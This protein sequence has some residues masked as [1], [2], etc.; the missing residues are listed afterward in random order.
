MSVANFLSESGFRGFGGD[1][2]FGFISN[3]KPWLAAI[4]LAQFLTLSSA[5]AELSTGQ[6][7][8]GVGPDPEA[9]APPTR[10]EDGVCKVKGREGAI[11]KVASELADKAITTGKPLDLTPTGIMP[12]LIEHD[13]TV[14][15]YKHLLEVYNEI[16]ANRTRKE[17]QDGE[18][19]A[20]GKL[21][22]DLDGNVKPSWKAF[23]SPFWSNLAET[24]PL[25]FERLKHQGA[26]S[27]AWE[28][29]LA[30]IKARFADVK[31]YSL[32]MPGIYTGK[33]INDETVRAYQFNGTPYP[34]DPGQVRRALAD[35]KEGI[36]REM[37][38][39]NLSNVELEALASEYLAK[40]LPWT[41][42]LLANTPSL[43]SVDHFGVA[44]LDNYYKE[45]ATRAKNLPERVNEMTERDPQVA[46]FRKET[47]HTNG[48]DG[49]LLLL[50]N[51]LLYT[52]DPWTTIYRGIAE[53]NL[54]Y[55]EFMEVIDL[56]NEE[57]RRRGKRM[58]DDS[59][60]PKTEIE[61]R[62][63]AYGPQVAPFWQ[64]RQNGLNAKL[65]ESVG[66]EITALRNGRF[67][68]YD[69]EKRACLIDSAGA[70]LSLYGL[71]KPFHILNNPDAIRG[72]EQ[73][74][75]HGLS[76][77][78]MRSMVAEVDK[79]AHLRRLI[80]GRTGDGAYY[81]GQVVARRERGDRQRTALAQQKAKEEQ[82][83]R[84][85]PRLARQAEQAR[86]DYIARETARI[87]K[88][89]E[90]DYQAFKQRLADDSAQRERERVAR[91]EAK[92]AEDE[93]IGRTKG[94]VPRADD[95]V[96]ARMQER[97]LTSIIAPLAAEVPDTRE[98]ATRLQEIQDQIA[99]VTET[100][101]DG[102]VA[103][104]R[105]LARQSMALAKDMIET[106]EKAHPGAKRRDVVNRLLSQ[107]IVAGI[108]YKPTN[109][110]SQLN[111]TD[112][113]TIIALKRALETYTDRRMGDP[114]PLSQQPSRARFWETF[115]GYLTQTEGYAQAQRDREFLTSVNRF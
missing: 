34:E 73:V 5:V 14:D 66:P 85:A 11:T 9:G 47:R 111:N 40:R 86:Q 110:N 104:I 52:R 41:Q 98:T 22:R 97:P 99:N 18:R 7:L 64:K 23:N 106:Y 16:L 13:F 113:S 26:N 67:P 102:R 53:N 77:E 96:V 65:R 87:K 36:Y 30:T 63:L 71:S 12:L 8:L 105:N 54:S 44:S 25:E 31:I 57:A 75:T 79:P 103:S 61:Y 114:G 100:T 4:V 45:F 81:A 33:L 2:M 84:D 101:G 78:E 10:P 20:E 39:L 17:L 29:R 21:L 3:G 95:L 55:G 68:S 42:P 1:Y 88:A 80:E 62:A 37:I 15:E 51:E 43:Y 109:P 112:Y 38:D 89:A 107:M 35:A 24:D 28:K 90:D 94:V 59:L 76:P 93:R 56:H 70:S 91:R 50:A 58:F 32:D 69:P 83:R 115:R 27:K 49:W 82:D 19:D 92:A 72:S 46:A 74:Y 108:K 6:H 60:L 48:K